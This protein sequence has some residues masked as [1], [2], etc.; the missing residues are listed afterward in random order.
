MEKN[1]RIICL[2]LVIILIVLSSCSKKEKPSEILQMTINTI[3]TI[4]TIYYKQDMERTNPQN[5]ND[6]IY[7]FREMYFKRLVSDS[8]V[9]VEGHW[10]MYGPDRKTVMYEDIFDGNRLVRKNNMDSLARIYDLE[11]YPGFKQYHFWSHSTLY[12]LQYEFKYILE[13]A[14]S[15]FLERLN[16]TII[17]N[18]DCFQIS[19]L[20]ENSMSMPGFAVGLEDNPGSISKTIY[21]IDKETNYPIRMKGEFYSVD[22]P[23]QVVFIDQTYYD[24]IFN[25]EMD[26][27]EL[28]NTSEK[29]VSGYVVME[30]RPE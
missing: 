15:Y 19:V 24:I 17:K 12:G 27:D 20:L 1:N 14:D 8:I 22:N 13:N 26:E 5:I 3:D 29:I 18:K 4:E 16:D 11:K 7:R 9:G 23:T 30:V 28:F 25:L 6:T 10:Y 21:F 2:G